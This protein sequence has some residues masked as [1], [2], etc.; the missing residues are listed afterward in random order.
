MP[1]IEALTFANGRVL[2][3]RSISREEG[4]SIITGVEFIGESTL[5]T[6]LSKGESVPWVWT[7][8]LCR[9]T[10]DSSAICY[11]AGGGGMGN[12]GFIAAQSQ[13]D[14]SLLWA[15]CFESSNPFDDLCIENGCLR[16]TNNHDEDWVVE[17]R[18]LRNIRVDRD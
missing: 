14:E 3:F 1:L 4:Y 11:L 8:P 2:R 12:V 18:D 5:E 16:A 17:L 6:E 10:D 9:V 15:A 13:N 7:D